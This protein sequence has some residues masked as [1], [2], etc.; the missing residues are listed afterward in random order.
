MKLFF[1]AAALIAA[2][3]AQAQQGSLENPGGDIPVSGIV[4]ISGWHCTARR[5]EIQVDGHPIVAGANTERLDVAPLCGK[6]DTGF[7]VLFNWGIFPSGVHTVRALADGVEFANRRVTVVNLGGEFLTG[8][9]G[10]ATV[11]DFPSVG[12]ST[13]LEWQQ[14]LQAFVAREKRNDAPSLAGRWNGANLEVRSG[15]RNPDANGNHGTYH[16]SMIRFDLDRL[17]IEEA[18]TSGLACTY[19]GP[20]V[21]QGTSRSASGTLTCSDGKQGRFTTK[22]ILVTPNEMSLRLAIQLD[23]TETCAI[24][25][26][27]GGSRLF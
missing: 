15:C 16:Q 2:T 9:S 24:D 5:I 20:Y 1:A 26:V 11:Y 17:V 4:A 6:P 25:A 10:S 22:D 13:V 18:T 21:Q 3:S 7:S 14:G 12:Q 27:L 8:K 23:T 19:V